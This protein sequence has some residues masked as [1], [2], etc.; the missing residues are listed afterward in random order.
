MIGCARK[1]GQYY[2]P[3]F[4]D[5]QVY[6]VVGGL[7]VWEY[8]DYSVGRM[9]G[10]DIWVHA[11]V[12]VIYAKNIGDPKKEFPYEVIDLYRPKREGDEAFEGKRTH[13][14]RVGVDNSRDEQKLYW[15]EDD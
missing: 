13:T 2:I 14:F 9:K 5:D 4:G 10:P 6:E 15:M 8:E 1:P 3:P 11:R 12:R 7:S